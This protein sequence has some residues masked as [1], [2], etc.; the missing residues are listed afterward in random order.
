MVLNDSQLVVCCPKSPK[1]SMGFVGCE[2]ASI[3]ILQGTETG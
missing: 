1:K 2:T 3:S